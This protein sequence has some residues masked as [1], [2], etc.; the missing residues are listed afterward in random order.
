MRK[1]ITVGYTRGFPIAIAQ[2][3]LGFDTL[4]Y[5]EIIYTLS[6]SIPLT[7]FSLM[8]VETDEDFILDN[9]RKLIDGL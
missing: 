9:M 6:G 1:K 2:D 7:P 4:N 8:Y 5:L 3:V